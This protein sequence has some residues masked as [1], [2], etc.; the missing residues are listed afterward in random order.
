MAVQEDAT[1]RASMADVL[2]ILD[3]PEEIA[4]AVVELEAGYREMAARV[5]AALKRAGFKSAVGYL[6]ELRLGHVE[7][8]HEVPAWLARAFARCRKS[9]LRGQGPK[10]KAGELKGVRATD[11]LRPH[12]AYVVANRWLLREI[13][14]AGARLAHASFEAG[15]VAVLF[16]PVSKCDVGGSGRERRLRCLCSP[17]V[18]ADSCPY[19]V[20]AVQ[21]DRVERFAGVSRGEQGAWDQPLFPTV[22]NQVPTKASMVQARRGPAAD[23]ARISGH[24]ARRSGA[25]RCAREGWPILAIQHLGRWASG[26]VLEY[27]EESCA[28]RTGT[29]V[30]HEADKPKAPAAWDARVA[31][32]AAEHAKV[33]QA[34]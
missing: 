32:A 12:A 33:A 28:E 2:G 18:R 8:R 30:A 21:V 29:G 1:K 7:A 4:T 10:A 27:V 34:L 11:V 6:G 24:S 3:A 19:H 16:L 23:P 9:P 26:Q 25:K 31:A 20:L 5:A 22:G 13:E 17:G 14:V 15:E